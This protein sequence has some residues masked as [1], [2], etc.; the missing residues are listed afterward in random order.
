VEAG[1]PGARRVERGTGS[2][3]GVQISFG[4]GEAPDW[5]AE[6][7]MSRPAGEALPRQPPP[8]PPPPPQVVPPPTWARGMGAALGDPGHSLCTP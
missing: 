7:V 4:G 2:S 1:T 6:G 3:R 8:A 5:C